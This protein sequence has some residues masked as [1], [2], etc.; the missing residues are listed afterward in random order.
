MHSQ[1]R[2]DSDVGLV[3]VNQRPN[4]DID[5]SGGVGVVA[6]GFHEDTFVCEEIPQPGMELDHWLPFSKAS[7]LSI[8]DPVYFNYKS[9]ALTNAGLSCDDH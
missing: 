4:T 3:G 2:R 8:K 7:T 6:L 5:I 1:M 9:A